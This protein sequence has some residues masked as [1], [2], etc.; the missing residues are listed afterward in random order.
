MK[1]K[2]DGDVFRGGGTE[3]ETY[4]LSIKSVKRWEWPLG[5][6][7]EEETIHHTYIQ[8]FKHKKDQRHMQFY[9]PIT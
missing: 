6:K 9:E 7:E 8:T 2:F 3:K 4:F 5:T 1:W